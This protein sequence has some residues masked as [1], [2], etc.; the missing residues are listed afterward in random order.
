MKTKHTYKKTNF[1]YWTAKKLN[2]HSMKIWYSIIA[3]M[4]L[5]TAWAVINRE[6]NKNPLISPLVSLPHVNQ[7]QA[8]EPEVVIPCEKDAKSYLECKV[9]QGKITWEEYDRLSK[10]INCESRWR[11]DV[12]NVNTNG[13]VDFGIMQINSI[14]KDISNADKLNYQKAIDWAIKKMHKDGSLNAWVCNRLVK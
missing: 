4:A 3:I 1:R 5:V 14:H 10:V 7:V 2:K 12:I 6:V 8:S 11:E 13:S 9:Y